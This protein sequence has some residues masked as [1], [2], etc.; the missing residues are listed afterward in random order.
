M[1]FEDIE[2]WAASEET[3]ADSPNITDRV[4]YLELVRLLHKFY[5]RQI[6]QAEA[7]AEKA[8]LRI[9]WEKQKRIDQLRDLSYIKQ[10]EAN[11]SSEAL[12]SEIGRAASAGKSERELLILSLRCIAD[13]TG[14][15]WMRQ[16]A[17][18]FQHLHN[19]AQT[20]TN[21]GQYEK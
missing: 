10:R 17:E 15:F 13:L 6:S 14:D 18:Q 20:S 19:H 7:A 2:H 4:Y 8:Q 1:N 12:R 21:G 11:A 16:L 3:P 9:E 5:D